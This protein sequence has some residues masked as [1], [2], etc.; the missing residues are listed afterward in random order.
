[1]GGGA[2]FTHQF[3]QAYLDLRNLRDGPPFG[4]NYFDNSV[5]ATYAHREYCLSLRSLYSGFSKNSWGVTPSDSDIGYVIWGLWDAK[6]PRRDLD[7]T[8]VP[9]AAGGS[10]MFAPHICLPA[11]RTMQDDF[12]ELVYGRY[13]FADAFHPGAGWVD[14]EVVG[15]DLGITLL[16]AENLR[17]RRVWNWFMQSPAIQRAIGKVFEPA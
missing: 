7:G 14:P 8:I 16:S 2:L 3:P 12:G 13:G 10:L 1:V 5:I 15:I 9:C 4:I 6:R 11:L 17:S